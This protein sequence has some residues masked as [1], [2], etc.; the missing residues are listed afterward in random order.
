MRLFLLFIYILIVVWNSES[1][2]G[3]TL[4]VYLYPLLR[5]F[6]LSSTNINAVINTDVKP[7]FGNHMRL[8]LY[9]KK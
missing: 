6:A 2:T 5:L 4:E 3:L 7:T 1:L 8:E 9:G